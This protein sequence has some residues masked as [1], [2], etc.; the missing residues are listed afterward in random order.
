MNENGNEIT[1]ISNRIRVKKRDTRNTNRKKNKTHRNCR[2]TH[3]DL[4][5]GL[6]MM[7]NCFNPI[8]RTATAAAAASTPC[9][10]KFVQRKKNISHT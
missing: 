6:S 4:I 5:Q 1:T 7:L 2:D 3:N 10:S 9:H 8:Y